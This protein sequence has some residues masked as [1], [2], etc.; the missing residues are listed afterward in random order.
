MEIKLYRAHRLLALK[1]EEEE[2]EEEER[3]QVRERGGGR[4][5]REALP[6]PVTFYAS[7]HVRVAPPLLRINVAS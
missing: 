6:S 2:E 1:P 4:R 7:L 3:Q 5:G